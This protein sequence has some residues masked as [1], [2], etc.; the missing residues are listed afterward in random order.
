MK[1]GQTIEPQK[2]EVDMSKHLKLEELNAVTGGALQEALEY[3]KNSNWNANLKGMASE[4]ANTVNKWYCEEDTAKKKTLEKR[5]S[6]LGSGFVQ[7]YSQNNPAA[8][9]EA[10]QHLSEIQQAIIW[11]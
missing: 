4:F 8:M 7:A 6:E 3:V 2:M 5:L 9:I 10:T 1:A 11:N